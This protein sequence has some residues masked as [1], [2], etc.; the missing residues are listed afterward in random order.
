MR[1]Y[2]Y[3]VVTGTIDEHQCAENAINSRAHLLPVQ[4]TTLPFYCFTLHCI[5][6]HLVLLAFAWDSSES[7]MKKR[8]GKHQDDLFV[9]LAYFLR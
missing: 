5:A 2:D 8:A 7:G 1:L 3:A 6:Y 4:C 9:K